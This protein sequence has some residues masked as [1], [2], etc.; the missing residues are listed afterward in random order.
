MDDT[1]IWNYDTNI[2]NWFTI[3]LNFNLDFNFN[4]WK[5]KC[6]NLHVKFQYSST[7]FEQEMTNF[8]A[9]CHRMIIINMKKEEILPI[10]DSR[11]KMI[12]WNF[13]SDIFR[14]FTDSNVNFA[15]CI[16]TF[17]P[18]SQCE[19]VFGVAVAKASPIGSIDARNAASQPARV[20]LCI[21]GSP[22][23]WLRDSVS[24]RHYRV[25]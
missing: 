15:P 19:N 1:G 14:N 5:W 21:S 2:I 25:W 13:A 12:N 4:I 23:N 18:S 24:K 11:I 9:Y 10:N 16:Q 20:S 8:S 17:S 22:G 3:K 7:V 6:I